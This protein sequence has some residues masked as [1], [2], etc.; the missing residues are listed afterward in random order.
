M[1]FKGRWIPDIVEVDRGNGLKEL[2]P[3]E[4][5]EPEPVQGLQ[6][7]WWP[8]EWVAW[9]AQPKEVE[10]KNRREW[11]LWSV[12]VAAF[13]LGTSLGGILQ[14]VYYCVPL[15]IGSMAYIALV[16]WVNR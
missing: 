8:K 15:F 11:I 14:Q 2:M 4:R 6:Y 1:K 10:K 9:R 3:V 16:A 5:Y 12:L 13:F 7:F